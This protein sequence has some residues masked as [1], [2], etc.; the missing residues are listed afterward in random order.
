MNILYLTRDT[1][2]SSII[3]SH[4]LKHYPNTKIE[5][6]KIRSTNVNYDYIIAIGYQHIIPDQV[7]KSAKNCAINFHPGSTNNPGA[8]C[9]SY[10]IYN[11]EKYSGVTCHHLT[12]KPDT[13]KVIIE[14]KFRIYKNDDFQ[15]VQDRAL[16]NTLQIFY[17]IFDIIK[18]DKK[19]PVSKSQ[20]K[21]KPRYQK[22]YVN[23]LLHIDITK[24][25]AKEIDLKIRCSNPKYPGPYVYI[26]GKKYTLR[27]IFNNNFIY[28]K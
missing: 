7:L 15:S 18:N 12:N 6:K 4:L 14:K 3:R 9:Y 20:W 17:E 22:N 11:R 5:T 27:T 1:W 23:D 19:M 28:G 26:K 10:P 21:R 25:T 13:G 24:D 8:G 2:Y 16:I